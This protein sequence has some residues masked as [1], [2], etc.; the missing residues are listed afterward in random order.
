MRVGCLNMP[1]DCPFFHSHSVSGQRASNYIN[2][3]QG[4]VGPGKLAM[5]DHPGCK[6]HSPSVVGNAHMSVSWQSYGSRVRSDGKLENICMNRAAL[7][8]V[9]QPR[10]RIFRFIGTA[11]LRVE[12]HRGDDPK[13][14]ALSALDGHHFSRPDV[15]VTG[16]LQALR[17]MP[18][19]GGRSGQVV[20]IGGHLS[21]AL[22]ADRERF[23]YGSLGSE[24]PTHARIP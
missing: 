7:R 19:E 24:C 18:L 20:R 22:R 14:A 5:V 10:F 17:G 3:W 2:L 4:T 21:V 11:T 12:G 15:T 13:A 23:V 1:V 16:H 6:Q 8:R 9:A